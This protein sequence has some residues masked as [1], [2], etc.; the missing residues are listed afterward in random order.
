MDL[1]QTKEIADQYHVLATHYISLGERE[2]SVE[3][4]LKQAR[5]RFQRQQRS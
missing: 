1:A 5:A 3:T 4:Q 2:L